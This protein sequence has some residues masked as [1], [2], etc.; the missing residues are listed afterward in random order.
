[1]RRKGGR[2]RPIKLPRFRHFPSPGLRHALFF[3]F[4]SSSID[5]CLVSFWPCPA[6]SIAAWPPGCCARPGHEVVGLFMR[7]GQERGG[8]LRG[9]GQS[10]A[11][12]APADA[13]DARRVAEQL[14]IPFYALNFEQEFGRI[15]DYF[16]AEYTAGRTPNPCIVCNTWLKFGKLL[17]YADS[18][19]AELI[20]T[21]HYAR[22]R[23]GR[24]R[25]PAPV[26]RPR[27]GQGPVL[28]ALGHRPRAAAAAA[29]SR[30]RAPE[31]GNP[32]D[33][34]RIGPRVA[35]KPDSQEICFVPDQD[36]ARFIRQH[37]GAGGHRG[38]DRHHRRRGGRPARRAWSDSPSASARVCGSP[39]ASR[40]MWSASS[41]RRAA[42]WWAPR[43][44]WPDENSPPAGPIGWSDGAGACCQVKIRYRSEPVEAG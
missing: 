33:C 39:S 35:E 34:G 31:S 15:I 23:A 20:A 40:A 9:P 14:G 4:T 26:P 17:E 2:H 13:D 19:G 29:V 10:R 18:I 25:R 6:A 1:M 41:R 30:G 21:G 11:V 7:H 38:R 32:A 16:V 37:R 5:P 36:H 22:L 12:A 42:W 28:R 8:G 44:N 24:R 3:N 27:S 43:R